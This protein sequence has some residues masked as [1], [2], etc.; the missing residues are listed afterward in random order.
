MFHVFWLLRSQFILILPSVAFVP[1]F[2]RAI[3]MGDWGFEPPDSGSRWITPPVATYPECGNQ[4]R[5][6]STVNAGRCPEHAWLSPSSGRN[7]EAQTNNN[8]GLTKSHCHNRWQST[9]IPCRQ[10]ACNGLH[11]TRFS[12]P[13]AQ[14]TLFPSPIPHDEPI[15]NDVLTENQRDADIL[16]CPYTESCILRNYLLAPSSLQVREAKYL[17]DSFSHIPIYSNLLYIIR[18]KS[19]TET[20]DTFRRMRNSQVDN[21]SG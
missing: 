5:S 1:E 9:S 7:L 15:S 6:S 11:H 17:S 14:L 10:L 13:P 16:F 12:G 4:T 3:V 21:Y 19:I 8:Q 2:S 18:Y 20:N